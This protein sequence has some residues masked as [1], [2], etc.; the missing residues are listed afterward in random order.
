MYVTKRLYLD[1]DTV[2]EFMAPPDWEPKRL[3]RQFWGAYR[4]GYKAYLNGAP[5]E[6]PYQDKRGGKHEHVIT[7]S[8]AFQHYWNE[9]YQNA[10]RGQLPAYQPMNRCVTR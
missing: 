10:K 7:Y 9:G 4:K 3:T 5:D 8:R 6:C 2:F 1:E